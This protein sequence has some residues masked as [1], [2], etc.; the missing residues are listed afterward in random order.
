[1]AEDAARA[2][3][4]VDDGPALADGPGH[5]LLAPDILAG[6]G[7]GDGDEGV[8]VGRRRD[9]DDVDVGPGQ[10][11]AEVRVSGDA[12]AG[13]LQGGGE[14]TASTSQTARRTEPS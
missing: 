13:D 11:L 4:G 5:R 12:G 10:D 6:L 1:M 9:V 2:A 3:D 14:V 8:P 7:G